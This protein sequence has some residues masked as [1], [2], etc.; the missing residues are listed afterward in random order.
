MRTT[1]FLKG[2]KQPPA[3][4]KNPPK[5]LHKKKAIYSSTRRWIMS[6][7]I[8]CYKKLGVFF[9][10]WAA[11]LQISWEKQ[12]LENTNF[13]QEPWWREVNFVQNTTSSFQLAS[14]ITGVVFI[15]FYKQIQKTLPKTLKKSQCFYFVLMTKKGK[16][17]IDSGALLL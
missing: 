5:L 16:L 17:D 3:F 4:P 6:V 14:I 10:H 12:H 15:S 2:A 8:Y 1:A 11:I 13:T 9:W 7:E